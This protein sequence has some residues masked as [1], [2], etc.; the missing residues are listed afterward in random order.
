MSL[1]FITKL[2]CLNHSSYRY[3]SLSVVVGKA[4]LQN[5]TWSFSLIRLLPW[6]KVFV[7]FT[8]KVWRI[9][10]RLLSFFSFYSIFL[11]NIVF[12]FNSWH[13]KGLFP[14]KGN[15]LSLTHA[16]SIIIKWIYIWNRVRTHI[17]PTLWLLG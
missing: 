5:R 6:L 7:G 3:L 17:F 9:I 16:S 8:K 4:R 11:F 2:W 1:L 15:F 12:G 10:F 14:F 13:C